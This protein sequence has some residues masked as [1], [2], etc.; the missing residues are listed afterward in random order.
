MLAA[1]TNLLM[2]VR[3]VIHSLQAVTG[4]ECSKLKKGAYM[5]KNKGPEEA[6]KAQTQGSRWVN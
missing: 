6:K 5:R 1:S 2:Y 4:K 3:A